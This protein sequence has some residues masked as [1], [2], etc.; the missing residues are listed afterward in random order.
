MRTSLSFG[1]HVWPITID[2]CIFG[3]R[4][5]RGQSLDISLVDSY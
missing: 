3:A 4:Y 2:G 5:P 1:T